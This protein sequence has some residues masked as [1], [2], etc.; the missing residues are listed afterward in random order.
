MS[1]SHANRRGY[2]LVE[3]VLA[4]GAVAIVLGLSAGLLHALLRLDRA[5]R[6]HV[7]ETATIGRLAR[8][9][10]QDVHAAVEAKVDGAGNRQA[11][12]LELI[13]APDRTIIYEMRARSMR[14]TEHRTAAIDRHETYLVPFCPEGGFLV[15]AQEGKVWVQLRLRRGPENETAAGP[16]SPGQ[17]LAIDAL[18][19]RHLVRLPGKLTAR[20]E[21][22]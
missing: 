7:V 5:G 19:G 22:P 12:K 1:R 15:Q 9:F 6:S 21:E 14:R 2:A 10:R 20:G 8:Q 4:I 17:V 18:A 13:C 16:G 11:P 3:V